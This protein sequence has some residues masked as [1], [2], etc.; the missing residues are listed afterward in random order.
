MS[1]L[2]ILGLEFETN[3]VITWNWCPRICPTVPFSVRIKISTFRTKNVL[4]GYFWLGILKTNVI[5]KIST[6]E[7]AKNEFLTHT[8]KLGIG[9]VFLKVLVQVKIHL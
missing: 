8:E 7:F 4:F 6:I 2:D 9:S 3:I 1:D 5:Y